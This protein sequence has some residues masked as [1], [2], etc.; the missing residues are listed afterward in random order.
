VPA[1]DPAQ[2]PARHK[3]GRWIDALDNAFEL[4]RIQEIAGFGHVDIQTKA[5]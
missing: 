4:G 5:K 2:H 1:N 3:P